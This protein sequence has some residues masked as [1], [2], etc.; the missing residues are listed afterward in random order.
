MTDLISWAISLLVVLLL[1]SSVWYIFGLLKL[2]VFERPR[3]PTYD[4]FGDEVAVEEN[5][6]FH[7]HTEPD[8]KLSKP[9]ETP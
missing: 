1:L 7:Q 2:P 4:R 6:D 5:P 3:T 9:G 8:E